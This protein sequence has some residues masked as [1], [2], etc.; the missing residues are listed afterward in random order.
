MAEMTV[1]IDPDVVAAHIR[2]AVAKALGENPDA[3][4]KAVVDEAMK[5]KQNSYD[6]K[7]VFQTGVENMIREVA[8]KVFREWLDTKRGDIRK[9]IAARL[10]A[11]GD[12]FVTQAADK[13]VAALSD[14]FYVSISLKVED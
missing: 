10:K 2:A 14:N 13:L 3:L 11:G 1:K 5:V 7:T 12:A 6:K 4:V 8:S 9:A